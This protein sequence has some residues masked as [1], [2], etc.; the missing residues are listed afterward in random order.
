MGVEVVKGTLALAL[1]KFWG[2]SAK[3]L[4]WPLS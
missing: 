3:P 2:D 4:E 1:P